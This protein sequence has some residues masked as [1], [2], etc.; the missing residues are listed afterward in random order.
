MRDFSSRWTAL[1][2][3]LAM[4]VATAGCGGGGGS[5]G[6]GSS[7]ASTTGLPNALAVTVDE[8]PVGL[9]EA[10]EFAVNTL[11]ASVTVCSPG[12]ATQC[13]T[14]DHVQVDTGSVG[15][16]LFKAQ[17]S[18]AAPKPA[19][20][21]TTGR[22][23]AECAQFADG[24]TW[25]SVAILDVQLGGRSIPSVAVNL[26]GD[27]A[28]GSAP[29]TCVSGPDES[30]VAAFG[31]NGLL[32]VGN[33]LQDCGTF[34]ATGAPVGLYYVCPTSASCQPVSVSP[35]RQVSNPVGLLGADNNGV[36]IQLPSVG[37]AGSPTV[38]G[39]MYF[40]I[41]SQTDNGHGSAQLFSL[42][43]DGTLTT[44]FNGSSVAGSFIDSGSN[45]TYFASAIPTCGDNP[46]FYCPVDGSGNPL[47]LTETATILGLNSAHATVSFSV[48]DADQM[49]ATNATAL[50]ALAGGNGGFSGDV[51]APF[52][53]GLPFFYG[54]TVFIVFEQNAVGGVAGPAL[55][56]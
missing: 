16:R 29:S 19:T 52:D 31:A 26:M 8:G 36:V 32:G 7:G 24:F 34:C 1:G 27:M 46:S 21:P 54:R 51:G 4:A 35:A 50:P 45:G 37:V 39:I 2:I 20:D 3:S 9:A 41:D 12:S 23:L 5:T 38:S 44:V 17:L 11:Y 14:I 18:A 25:G 13:Q 49:F 15:L 43:A 6:T 47:V 28:V 53:W 30:T 55:A 33:F 42:D 56:F 40:G 22:A 10:N 48:G